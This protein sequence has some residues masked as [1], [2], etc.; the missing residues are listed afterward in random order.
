MPD[1]LDVLAFAAHPDDIE[2]SCGGTIIKMVEEGKKV[3]IVDLTRGELGT[4]GNPELREQEANEA[5]DLMGIQLRENLRLQDG[6]IGESEEEISAVVR[7]LR[8]HRPGIV[9]AC[10]MEDRHPDHGNAA[11]LI[12]RAVFLSGLKNFK[13]IDD[14]G[15]EPWRPKAVYHYIQDRYIE[16]DFV[17]DITGQYE[18]RKEVI[19]CFKSQFFDPNSKETQTYISTKKFQDYLEARAIA[20]GHRIGV[21]YGEGFTSTRKIGVSDITK[22]I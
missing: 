13:V 19:A 3:G 2:M 21:H 10:A 12:E 22:L 6:M 17:V 20:M 4:R 18:K 8:R 1:S 15:N 14:E 9:I 11:S 7:A 5:S 16:P